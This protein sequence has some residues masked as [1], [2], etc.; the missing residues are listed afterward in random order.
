M[1]KN[2]SMCINVKNYIKVQ[3]GNSVKINSSTFNFII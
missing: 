3:N 2:V 1:Q